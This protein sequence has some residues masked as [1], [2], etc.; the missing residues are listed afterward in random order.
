[1][2]QIINF[3]R[4]SYLLI[5]KRYVARA[6]LQNPNASIQIASRSGSISS[7]LTSLGSQVLPPV[8]LDIASKSQL[9]SL[10]SSGN[11]TG[12]VNLVGIMMES[13][14]NTFSKSQLEGPIHLAQLCSTLTGITKLIHVSAIGAN[15]Q[16]SI[17]YART[18]GLAELEMSKIL[19][20]K[21]VILR[22]SLVFGKEDDFFNV[23]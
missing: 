23:K 11:F 18:K 8:S 5:L 10:L 13:K 21:S 17:P 20:S 9:Q 7:E 4:L 19:G 14:S 16:S 22:P 3:N 6:I 12:V 1:M 2:A 15:S